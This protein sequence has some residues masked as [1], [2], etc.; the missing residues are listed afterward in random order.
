M[1]NTVGTIRN[2]LE[3]WKEYIKELGR[4]AWCMVKVSLSGAMEDVT[5]INDLKD[6]YGKFEWPDGRVYEGQFREGKMHGR[7]RFKDTFGHISE[8]NWENGHFLRHWAILY[9]ILYWL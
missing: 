5:Y 8:G 2:L 6:G 7:G 3:E 1:G 9:L 4:M